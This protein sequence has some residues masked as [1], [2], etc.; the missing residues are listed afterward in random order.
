MSVIWK[1]PNKHIVERILNI[2]FFV[3]WDVCFQKTVTLSVRLLS[4]KDY[5]FKSHSFV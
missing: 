5:V 2:A 3:S 4:I 1:V